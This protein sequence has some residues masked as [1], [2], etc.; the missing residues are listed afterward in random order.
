MIRRLRLALIVALL[1]VLAG[2]Q[3]VAPALT[4]LF[5]AFSQD[6][7]SATAVNYS[8]RY[9]VEVENLLAALARHATGLEYQ[10]QLV[11]AGY[12]PPPP[13]YAQ[14]QGGGFA[15]PGG[16]PPAYGQPHSG[17][18]QAVYHD[19]YAVQQ[20][21]YGSSIPGYQDPYA[22]P[23]GGVLTRSI[24]DPAPISL[25]VAILAQRAGTDRL[26]IVNDGDVLRD[27]R[28]D[29][30]RGDLLRFHFQANCACWVYVIGIDAT[31]F[32]ARIFPDPE[33]AHSNPVQPG[34]NYLMPGGNAWWALDDY[35]GIE[36]IYFVASRE[37]RPDI[38][39]AVERLA[40]QPRQLASPTY[41]PVREPAIVPVTRG[42]VRVE[43]PAPV[44]V[45]M[46]PSTSPPAVVTPTI[47]TN[48]DQSTDVVITRWFRHE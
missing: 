1:T 14:Q 37:Q 38:E 29:P 44:A 43:A 12:Q 42:L 30:S 20:S 6:L 11:Q 41:Q 28:G 32:V 35:R 27:G 18:G 4:A 34:V 23:P 9:A 5:M 13:R 31:G 46:G 10:G 19:P 40:A 24:G 3:A 26:D 36:Q 45:P 7:L 33:E 39:A 22:F 25:G 15:Q 17:Y 21:P 47:F 48:S 16:Y 2:C 8:P